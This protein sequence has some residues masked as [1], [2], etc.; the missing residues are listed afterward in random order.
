MGDQSIVRAVQS[1]LICLLLSTQHHQHKHPRQHDQNR[2]HH[3]YQA[4]HALLQLTCKHR[5][6]VL[7]DRSRPVHQHLVRLKA[8]SIAVSCVSTSQPL[9]RVVCG[10]MGGRRHLRPPWR[11]A[12]RSRSTLGCMSTRRARLSDSWTSRTVYAPIT[13]SQYDLTIPSALFSTVSSAEAEIPA[14]TC[15]LTASARGVRCFEY[16][17]VLASVRR[18]RDTILPGETHSSHE[19]AVP[20]PPRP[21]APRSFFTVVQ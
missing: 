6:D 14:K 19:L 13:S 15:V 9:L 11:S 2:A 18:T 16:C 3:V 21:Y 8:G 4:R 7:G 5:R 10:M 1:V 12:T 20:A 17:D